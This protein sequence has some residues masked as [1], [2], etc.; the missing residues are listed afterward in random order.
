VAAG[1]ADRVGRGD[2]PRAGDEPFL[3]TLLERDIV[4]IRGTHVSDGGETGCQCEAGVSR[5]NQV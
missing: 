4:E 2:D 3:D 1:G 5:A